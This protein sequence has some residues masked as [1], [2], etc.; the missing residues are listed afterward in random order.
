MS[1]EQSY[2]RRGPG[3]PRG[4]TKPDVKK[5]RDRHVTLSG[6]AWGHAEKQ[7]NASQYIEALI[8]ADAGRQ[9]AEQ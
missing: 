7:G 4:S 3:R 5:R 9:A 8:L 2:A 1:A 6:D